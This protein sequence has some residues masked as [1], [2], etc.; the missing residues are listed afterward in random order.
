MHEAK[1]VANNDE[2]KLVRKFR[3]FKE[4]LDLFRIV[5]IALATDAFDFS[6]LS[7]TSCSLDILELY[8]GVCGKINDGPKVIIQ[9]LGCFE[10]LEKFDEADRA[11]K[12]RVFR[13]CLN[14]SLE[15]LADIDT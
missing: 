8:F 1:P 9:A 7:G 11:D 10:R 13:C 15:I 3:F 6:N 5:M 4:I 12:L 14:Y 2:G